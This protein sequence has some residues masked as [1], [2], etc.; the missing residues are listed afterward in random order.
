MVLQVV[1]P[2]EVLPGDEAVSQDPEVR[3]VD[4]AA[5][6]TGDVVDSPVEVEA[7][8]ATAKEVELEEEAGEEVVEA[9]KY[10]SVLWLQCLDLDSGSRRLLRSLLLCGDFLGQ[11]GYE[12]Q[13]AKKHG[14]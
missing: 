9:T 13:T 1:V 5:S 2:D 14:L 7:I 6:V 10:S 12:I 4:E 11:A 3:L 8:E